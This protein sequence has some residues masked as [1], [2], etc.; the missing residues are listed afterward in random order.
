MTKASLN[1]AAAAGCLYLAG[2]GDVCGKDGATLADPMCGSGTFLIEGALMAT[3]TAPGLF[4]RD[5]PFQ[6]WPDFDADAWREAREEAKDAVRPASVHLWGNDIHMGA[7]NLAAR[8][9]DAAG[10]RS[11]VKF[12]HGECK[13]WAVPH[14][15]GLVVSNPP[16]GQR[17]LA[18]ND[19]E[20]VSDDEEFDDRGNSSSQRQG[21]DNPELTAAWRDLSAFLKGQA[22]GANAFLLS[23]NSKATAGLRLK[24]EGK[25][26]LTI[27]GVDCRL[28]KYT[29]Y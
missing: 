14:A 16:W 13:S 10:I 29:M 26:P 4:R 23:G 25:V 19:T 24:A 11:L 28:L 9:A 12:H 1:E 21:D 3:N 5:W 20:E 17:L 8:D 22:K 18:R 27:G 2:W 15:P 7:L 6:A